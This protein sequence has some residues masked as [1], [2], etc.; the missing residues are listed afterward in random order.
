MLDNTGKRWYSLTMEY[1]GTLAIG[2]II[3]FAWVIIKANT[4]QANTDFAHKAAQRHAK[5]K[6]MANLRF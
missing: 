4:G 6:R 1:G 3:W 2:V 5:E